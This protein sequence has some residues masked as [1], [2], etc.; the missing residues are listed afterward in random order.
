MIFHI[1]LILLF[2]TETFSTNKDHYHTLQSM[3]MHLLLLLDIYFIKPQKAWSSSET[4][5]NRSYRFIQEHLSGKLIFKKLSLCI[6]C[7]ITIGL[8]KQWKHWQH[9]NPHVCQSLWKSEYSFLQI[10][11]WFGT[12]RIFLS[13]HLE[14]KCPNFLSRSTSPHPQE[15]HSKI[16]IHIYICVHKYVLVY[17]YEYAYIYKYIHL[18]V[19]RNIYMNPK[20]ILPEQT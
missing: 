10:R 15:W 19:N 1:F 11:L 17:I 2:D 14:L 12:Y 5:T 7:K 3:A 16:N 20:T 8:V 13:S 9:L 6:W 4:C 18:Y